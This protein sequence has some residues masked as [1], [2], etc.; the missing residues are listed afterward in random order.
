FGEGADVKQDRLGGSEAWKAEDRLKNP[1][2]PLGPRGRV[3][4]EDR[5]DRRPPQGSLQGLHARFGSRD[6]LE[7][8]MKKPATPRRKGGAGLRNLHRNAGEALLRTRSLSGIRRPARRR[9]AFKR[10]LWDPDGL[11]VGSPKDP[12]RVEHGRGRVRQK[13]DRHLLAEN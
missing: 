9:V 3:E 6:E 2:L 12:P 7:G 13:P 8:K 1:P 10:P 5:L 11:N 4:R